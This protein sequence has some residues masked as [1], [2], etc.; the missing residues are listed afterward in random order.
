VVINPKNSKELANTT[1][2]PITRSGH[3]P[4]ADDWARWLEAH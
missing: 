4:S 1:L 3:K 2:E